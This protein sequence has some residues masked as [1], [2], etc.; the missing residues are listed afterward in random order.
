M[1]M[2]KR[3]HEYVPI[4]HILIWNICRHTQ[5]Y[6]YTYTNIHTNT[7]LHIQ[8]WIGTHAYTRTNALIH[9]CTH[10]RMHTH[11]HS[12]TQANTNIHTS[13]RLHLYLYAFAHTHVSARNCAHTNYAKFIHRHA[14]RTYTHRLTYRLRHANTYPHMSQLVIYRTIYT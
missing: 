4:L 2:H 9:T 5:T 7:H 14:L 12:H 10:A 3:I 13:A 8:A 6:D 1:C 11:T